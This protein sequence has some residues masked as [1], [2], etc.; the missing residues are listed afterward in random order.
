MD[1]A[2]DHP[3]QSFRVH[4]VLVTFCV[5]NVALSDEKMIPERFPALIYY[6]SFHNYD[7]L[8]HINTGNI[9]IKVR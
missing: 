4:N 6:F 2:G 5:S 9:N 3:S 8:Q 7:S 1:A